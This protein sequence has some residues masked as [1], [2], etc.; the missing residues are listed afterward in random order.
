M[1]FLRIMLRI[2][3]DFDCVFRMC[4]PH[5]SMLSSPALGMGSV[6]PQSGVPRPYYTHNIHFDFGC[7]LFSLISQFLVHGTF[8]RDWPTSKVGQ[9]SFE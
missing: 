9:Y 7:V 8:A 4:T 6:P 2:R 5:E 1:K 3:V